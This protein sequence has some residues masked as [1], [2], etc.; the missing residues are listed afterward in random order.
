MRL[1]LELRRS[2]KPK[3]EKV[4]DLAGSRKHMVFFVCDLIGVI[5]PTTIDAVELLMSKIVPMAPPIDLEIRLL[6]GLA[7]AMGLIRKDEI[8]VAGKGATFFS[9]ASAEALQHPYHRIKWVSLAE[10]RS[11]FLSGLQ[12]IPE[13]VVV[14]KE[15]NSRRC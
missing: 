2:P 7:E 13:A 4:S 15:I 8:T 11:E 6:V 9:P 12:S 1:S 10:L 5:A 14:M 3:P